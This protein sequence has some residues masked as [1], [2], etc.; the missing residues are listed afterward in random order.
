M[1][2][3]ACA[4]APGVRCT[5]I[6][7]PSST[8]A[9]GQSTGTFSFAGA[10]TGPLVIPS[11]P[12]CGV[13]GTTYV[14]QVLGTVGGTQYKFLIGIVSY[15]GPSTYSSHLTVNLIQVGGIGNL[16][17]DGRLPV[18]ITVTNGGKAG[19]V[20]SDLEGILKVTQTQLS[21]GHVSGSWTCA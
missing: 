13:Q 12:A 5:G 10:V 14:M 4:K 11:F 15:H 16:D 3:T 7:T 17:N 19:T 8:V 20:S 21:T 2:A 6:V 9:S 18:N 1:R